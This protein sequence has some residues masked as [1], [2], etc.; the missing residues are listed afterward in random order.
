MRPYDTIA[1]QIVLY[2]CELVSGPLPTSVLDSAIFGFESDH[3]I[4]AARASRQASRAYGLTQGPSRT[5]DR[6]SQ[7][8]RST[9]VHLTVSWQREQN[10][11]CTP[12][13][14]SIP[15]EQP[16]STTQGQ[17]HNMASAEE[18]HKASSD[19]SLQ[20]GKA[21]IDVAAMVVLFVVLIV[22]FYFW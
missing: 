8:E 20:K 11:S 13:K 18:S 19:P 12:F 7:G 2:G 15:C 3:D 1:C 10:L 5:F 9:H 14:K 22:A 17:V 4:Y 21:W 6:C 16:C